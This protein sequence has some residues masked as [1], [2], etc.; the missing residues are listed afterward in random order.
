MR[1]RHK[2]LRLYVDGL[3]SEDFF[4]GQA[5][6]RTD[7]LQGLDVQFLLVT[8][9]QVT[10]GL[11]GHRLLLKLDDVVEREAR[12]GVEDYRVDIV[13][14]T[15]ALSRQVT[16]EDAGAHDTTSGEWCPRCC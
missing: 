9:N 14:Q 11:T 2:I 8:Q 16:V 3:V 10:V 13:V 4:E 15:Q 7:L 5:V 6:D 1:E 12:Q